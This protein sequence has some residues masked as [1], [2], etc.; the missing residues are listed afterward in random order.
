MDPLTYFNSLDR[1]LKKILLEDLREEGLMHQNKHHETPVR[2][3]KHKNSSNQKS[4]H[5]A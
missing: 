3:G 1:E 5:L 2:V 4:S